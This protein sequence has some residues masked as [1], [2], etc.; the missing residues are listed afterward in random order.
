MKKTTVFLLGTLALLATAFAIPVF[1]QQ[2]SDY[3]FTTALTVTN[4]T[5]GALTNQAVAFDINWNS[6]IDAGYLN[7]DGSDILVLAQDGGAVIKMM[8]QSTSMDPATWWLPIDSLANGASASFT[9]Y[10]GGNTAAADNPQFMFLSGATD[11]VDVADD[12]SLRVTDDATM[13]IIGFEAVSFPTSGTVQ[14]SG[15]ASNS[16]HMTLSDAGALSVVY[17]G[18]SQGCSLSTTIDE[19]TEYHIIASRGDNGSECNLWV[20][21]VLVDTDSGA[22]NILTN[23]GDYFFGGAAGFAGY[24]ARTLVHDASGAQ[25]DSTANGNDGTPTNGPIGVAGPNAFIRG[26]L[27]YDSVDDVVTVTD[28]APIQNIWDGG[29]TIESWICPRS[30]GESNAGHIVSKRAAGN[31]DGWDIRVSDESAGLMRLTLLVFFDTAN[32]VWMTTD[33]VIPINQCTHV[34]VLYD[35]DSPTNNPTFILSSLDGVSTEL[36]VGDGINETGTPSGTRDSD[37]G[38]NLI[39][40]NRAGGTQTF[41]G[42]LSDVRLWDDLRT[43]QEIEDNYLMAV[44]GGSAG[45]AGYWKLDNRVLDLDFEPDETSQT[46]EGTSGNGWE[47]EGDIEDTS[48]EDNDGTYTF[49]RDMTDITRTVGPITAVSSAASNVDE[50]DPEFVDGTVNPPIDDPYAEG[51]A[52]SDFGFPLNIVA[53]F[54]D[55]GSFP[56]MLLAGIAML[57]VAFFAGFAAFRFTRMPGAGPVA[58][59]LF[60]GA[61]VYVTPLPNVLV[62]LLVITLIASTAMMDRPFEAR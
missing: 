54:A 12:A 44:A 20:N 52:P 22:G 61:M 51:S 60:G 48:P 45:L 58:A 38:Q 15:R 24:F 4:T 36:T 26:A 47:W 62:L 32:G 10:T 40:G 25:P 7:P 29:G 34:A 46:Q 6:L 53:V 23:A 2:A 59:M 33:R 8:A 49:I 39:I 5:G 41:D 35:A 56:L 19:G 43:Q 28:A 1:A 27:D 13:E 30:D 42:S 14:I 50:Q 3:D 55:A 17:T 11:T 57:I 21:D 16:Y 31:A 9:L 18:V 37:V